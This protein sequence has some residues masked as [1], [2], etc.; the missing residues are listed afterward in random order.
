MHGSRRTAVRTALLLAVAPSLVVAG[1]DRNARG[2]LIW[3][4]ILPWG[5][6]VARGRLPDGRPVGPLAAAVSGRTVVLADTFAHRV[7]VWRRGGRGGHGPTVVLVPARTGVVDVALMAG[8]ASGLGYA[9]DGEGALWRL[10]VGGGPATLLMRLW[11]AAG[12]LQVISGLAVAARGVPVA[13]VTTVTREETSRRLL[14][15]VRPGPRVIAAAKIARAVRDGAPTVAWLLTPPG[16]R[17]AMV[18]GSRGIWVLGRRMDGGGAEL[19]ALS[20]QGKVLARRPFPALPRPMDLLGVNGG[21]AYALAASGTARARVVAVDRQGR[22][23][24]GWYLPLGDRSGN[25]PDLPHPV[26]VGASGELLTLS[27]ET[28]GLRLRLFSSLP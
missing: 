17:R 21:L 23:A 16:V 15:L 28:G 12:E 7:L 22:V 20:L 26:A 24:S 2:R 5:T 6:G 13:D 3:Q 1:C 11:A 4:H 18:G 25:A 9:V 27:A 19:V 14:D 10:P 8:V